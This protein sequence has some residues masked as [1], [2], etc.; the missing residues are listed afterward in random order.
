MENVISKSAINKWVF[1][2][3]NYPYDFIERCWQDNPLMASHIRGK[4]ESCSYDINRLYCELDA[5]NESRL[6]DWVLSNYHTE[7]KVFG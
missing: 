3:F 4:F 1:F 7:C 2:C 5:S 6:L